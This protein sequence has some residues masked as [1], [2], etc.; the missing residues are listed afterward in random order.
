MNLC[1]I[2]LKKKKIK[3]K[4]HEVI[5]LPYILE[6]NPHKGKILTTVGGIVIKEL[7]YKRFRF[8]LIT[9]G[10]KQKV[11]S[12]G[13][14]T[15]LLLKFVK[16]SDKKHQQKIIKEIKKVLLMIGPDGF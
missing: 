14:L 11:L 7:K 5:D 10:Y 15:Y 6:E 1:S 13:G 3:T 8:Y 4:A 2:R 12:K 16:M 9:D